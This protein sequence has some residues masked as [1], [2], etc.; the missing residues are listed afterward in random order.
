MPAEPTVCCA[1]GCYVGRYYLKKHMLTNKHL[2]LMRKSQNNVNN[3]YLTKNDIEKEMEKLYEK[4]DEMS[5]GEYLRECNRLQEIYR[6]I[7]KKE[8]N[9]KEMEKLYEKMDEINYWEFLRESDRLEEI[10]TKLKIEIENL[11]V[12]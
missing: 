8:E 6:I 3:K 12:N 1:C 2:K 7:I 5:S 9:E 4:M 10:H 11:R